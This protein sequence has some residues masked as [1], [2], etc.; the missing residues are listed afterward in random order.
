M[1]IF[2]EERKDILNY[3]FISLCLSCT[4]SAQKQKKS[5]FSIAYGIQHQKH[6]LIR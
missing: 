3:W 1:E 5:P 2:L 4:E 6:S